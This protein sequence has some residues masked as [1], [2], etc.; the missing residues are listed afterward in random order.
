LNHVTRGVAGVYAR[1]NYI[2]E[3]RDAVERLAKTIGSIVQ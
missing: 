1:H 2:E 3:K